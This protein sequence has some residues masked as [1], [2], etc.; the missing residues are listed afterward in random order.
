VTVYILMVLS[1]AGP[2]PA[3]PVATTAFSE[4]QDCVRQSQAFNGLSVPHAYSWCVERRRDGTTSPVV[5]TR[6][7][8]AQA[9]DPMAALQAAAAAELARREAA[10]KRAAGQ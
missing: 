8:P 3:Q 2:Q 7:L 9:A 4:V 6:G 5:L 1:L 10:Q